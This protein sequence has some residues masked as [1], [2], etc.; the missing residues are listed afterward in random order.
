MAKRNVEEEISTRMDEF[1]AASKRLP[2][3]NDG[4]VNVLA[5]CRDLGLAPSDAQHF[6]R[7]EALKATINALAE[8]QGILPIGARGRSDEDEIIERRLSQIATQAKDD[9]QAAA[10]QSAAAG[11]MLDELRAAQD[12]IERLTLQVRALEEK[13]RIYEDGGIPPRI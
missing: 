13:L 2:A 8:E 10:E 11:V 12:E 7:K 6:H 1:I 3:T 5:L 9:A 4:K